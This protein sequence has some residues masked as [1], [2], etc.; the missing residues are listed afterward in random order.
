MNPIDR[1]RI[2]VVGLGARGQFHLET[3]LLREDCQVVLAIDPQAAPRERWRDQ[4]PRLAE[5][6]EPGLLQAERVQA[7]WLATP[8]RTLPGLIEMAVGGGCALVLEPWLQDLDGEVDRLLEWAGD[9]GCAVVVHLP[10][11]STSEFRLTRQVRESGRLGAVRSIS[12]S[13]WQLSPPLLGGES[14]TALARQLIPWLDQARILA[15]GGGS[16]IWSRREGGSEGSGSNARSAIVRPGGL[17]ILLDFGTETIGWLDLQWQT[18]A[19]WDSGW[20]LRGTEGVWQ[21]TGGTVSSPAGELLEFRAD[22]LGQEP[23][24]AYDAVLRSLR[25]LGPN[26]GEWREVSALGRLV[27]QIL[28]GN[29]HKK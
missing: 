13:I 11:R 2:A 20:R 1:L 7:V 26:P 12:R 17:E 8:E 18:P 5:S 29:G 25:G 15:G 6:L 27:R 23:G 3:L 19:A 4:V 10:H 16:V 28:Q 14:G 24:G 9:K 21:P 22:E